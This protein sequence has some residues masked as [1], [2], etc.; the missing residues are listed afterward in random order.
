MISSRQIRGA[1]GLLKITASELAELA[2][3]TWKTVQRFE[4]ASDIPPSRSG[5][6][7]RVKAALEDAGIEFI[8]DPVTSPGVRLRR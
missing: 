3:V 8:G 4:A 5:T 1:R 6:L 2:G 7:E